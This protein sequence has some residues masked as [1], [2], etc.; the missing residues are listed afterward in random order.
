MR[1]S[2]KKL[3]P[4]R[5]SQSPQLGPQFSA[6]PLSAENQQPN[7]PA[8]NAQQPVVTAS[9]APVPTSN[10]LTVRPHIPLPIG[11]SPSNTSQTQSHEWSEGITEA[12]RQPEGVGASISASAGDN[13]RS[14]SLALRGQLSPRPAEFVV[15]QEGS[16]SVD[17]IERNDSYGIKVLYNP[18]SAAVDI[19]FVH[20]LTGNA[21][22]TWLHAGSGVHWPRD[23]VK[24]NIADARVMTFGY[25]ADVVK[26]WT[27]AAQDGVSGFA[28]DLLGSLAGH[29]SGIA[30]RASIAQ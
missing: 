26:F 4:F 23:L 3:N 9:T 1:S 12:G 10:S 6:P 7:A 22:T 21:F 16:G 8:E 19:V 29:K 5:G 15:P 28:N 25:D 11:S 14:S 20:G 24:R 2:L 18:P 27:H 30:V 13:S 17:R